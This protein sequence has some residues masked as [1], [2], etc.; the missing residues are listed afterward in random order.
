MKVPRM[1]ALALFAVPI[2]VAA[3]VVPAAAARSQSTPRAATRPAQAV[4]GSVDPKPVFL[5]D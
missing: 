4:D 2:A 1:V 5:A 3:A